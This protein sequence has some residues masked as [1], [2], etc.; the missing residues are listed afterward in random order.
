MRCGN[1]YKRSFIGEDLKRMRVAR[2]IRQVALE[3]ES[4]E[5]KTDQCSG[6]GSAK[7]V[8]EQTQKSD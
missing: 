7:Y 4:T 6:N 8:P 1:A 3:E 2:H 5:R